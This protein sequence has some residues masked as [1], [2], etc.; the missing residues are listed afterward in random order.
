MDVDWENLWATGNTGWD[1]GEASPAL[2]KLISDEATRHLVPEKGHGLVPGCGAGYDVELL[3]TKDRRMTGMDLSDTCVQNCLKIHP[4]AASKNYEI[5]KGD[6]YKFEY[7]SG[8]Y[9]FAYDYTF[10][11]AMPPTLRPDWAARYAEIIQPDGVLITLMYPLIEK[12]GGPPYSVSEQLYHDLLSPNFDLVYI[13]DAVGH[14]PRVGREK[15][16]VW[17][18]KHQ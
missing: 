16:S 17:K 7:P 13:A 8:G 9:T 3:A 5:V 12:E 11:C 18:R 14:G 2:V 15:I 1:A 6:F 10:L 4:E